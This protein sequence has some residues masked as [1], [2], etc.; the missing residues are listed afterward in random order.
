M[1]IRLSCEAIVKNL[2]LLLTTILFLLSLLLV[3]PAQ[4]QELGNQEDSVP[5]LFTY[6]VQTNLQLSNQEVSRLETYQSEPTAAS[7]SIVKL[8]MDV[9][10]EADRVNLNLPA[11]ATNNTSSTNGIESVTGVASGQEVILD[12]VRI[13]QRSAGDYSWFAQNDNLENEAIIVVQDN[14]IAGIIRAGDRKYRL[15]SV[16]DSYQALILLDES[17]FPPDHPPEAFKKLEASFEEEKPQDNIQD[18]ELFDDGSIIDVLV[19]Y[20]QAARQREGGV[21]AM[22]A[23]V[24]LAIDDTNRSYEVSGVIPRLRLVHRYETNYNESGDMGRDLDRFRIQNDGLID[25]VHGL[26]D[27]YA[28][29]VAILM[30]DNGGGYCGLAY[31]YPSTF[32]YG[33][34]VVDE[35]CVENYTFGHEI[36]HLQGAR[37]NPEVDPSNNPFPYGH[38][39]YYKPGRWRT[40]MSYNCEPERNCRRGRFWSTPDRFINNVPIGT[41]NTHNNVR[42]LNETAS[43]V[44]NFLTTQTSAELKSA[45]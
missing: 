10:K 7:I 2:V 43:R 8:E 30:T 41:A 16:N 23:L 17:A 1:L 13:E 3:N 4:A 20:T 36:G 35:E 31:L 34:G 45:S 37:H 27:R 6:P 21:A 42:V 22:N 44:A 15:R 26:R 25:E 18:N 24:Q 28:A 38:G 32:D 33:F 29:D 9:L 19:A 40:I 39:Y 14:T 12:D 11:S 5:N